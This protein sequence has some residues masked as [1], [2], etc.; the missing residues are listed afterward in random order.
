MKP[1]E[2]ICFRELNKSPFIK[3]PIKEN[4]STFAHKVS[5]I[6]QIQLGAVD[7]PTDK[8][9]NTIRRQYLAEKN[10]VFDRVHRLTRCVVDCKTY[11]HDAVAT[12]NSLELSRS[13]LA[14]Y[15][16]NSPL[17]LRQ[18]NGI[19]PAALRK[20]VQ[21]NITTLAHLAS[22]DTASIER[23]LS[24]NPPFGKK[25]L[26][27]VNDL[28]WLTLDAEIVKKILKSGAPV[29]VQ[30]RARL[31]L[32]NTKFPSFQ[33][34]TLSLTFLA[35]V[36]S[37]DLGHYWRGSIKRLEKAFEITFI[38]EL[39]D[40]EDTV[41][42]QIAC[43][44]LVGTVRRVVLKPD[45]PE[46]AFSPRPAPKAD[47]IRA[48]NGDADFEWDDIEEADFLA[49]LTSIEGEFTRTQRNSYGRDDNFKDID[50]FD[51][52]GHITIPEEVVAEQ[53]EPLQLPSGK[54]MC[55]HRCSDGRETKSGNAC[56]HKCCHEGIDKPRKVKKKVMCCIFGA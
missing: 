14:E 19:G 50:L 17:Q 37:G 24:R 49:A 36:S 51:D 11:D 10:I 13:I 23:V 45:I 5:L 30:I 44:E 42:C 52:E 3:S 46:S 9:F 39:L 35:E 8:D 18:I 22:M 27:F 47:G 53:V 31:G 48:S 41:T 25:I 34:K 32:A 4:I 16:E 43:D 6:I 15:W 7:L 56:K 21:K 33:H 26:D 38:C 2:R 55:N 12:H 28:P 40:P 20:L 54:W 1:T 29:K